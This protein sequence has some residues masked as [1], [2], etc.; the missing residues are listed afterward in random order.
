MSSN[1]LIR[2]V[3]AKSPIN[4]AFVKYWG[5][6][7]EERVIPLHNSISM[8]LNTDVLRS[9]T[10]VGI[11]EANDHELWLNGEQAEFTGRLKQVVQ[12]A[13]SLIKNPIEVKT[14]TGDS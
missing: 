11:M 12:K 2:K 8:T 9:N 10:K 13:Q 7:H 1:R 14:E 5:K 3:Q 6:A 4:L